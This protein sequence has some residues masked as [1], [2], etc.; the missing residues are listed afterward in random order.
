[1][2]SDGFE[3]LRYLE[4][5]RL[6]FSPLLPTLQHNS[7]DRQPTALKTNQALTIPRLYNFCIAIAQQD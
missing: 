7:Q 6:V 3:Q 2:Q 5:R 1:V 4:A